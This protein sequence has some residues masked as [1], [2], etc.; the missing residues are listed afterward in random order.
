[1]QLAVND[2]TVDQSASADDTIYL[3]WPRTCFNRWLLASEDGSIA[4]HHVKCLLFRL[5]FASLDVSLI[6][7]D[8]LTPPKRSS[9]SQS[10]STTLKPPH[11]SSVSLYFLAIAL[12]HQFPSI[13]TATPFATTNMLQRHLRLG[14]FVFRIVHHL[15]GLTEASIVI[16]CHYC[17]YLH[18]F[19]QVPAFWHW[20]TCQNTHHNHT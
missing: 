10:F 2:A 6:S 8:H 16:I 19:W 3:P 20:C 15:G 12:Q 11:L 1:M 4:K 7:N 14:A 9:I 5:R 18:W 17:L 13:H